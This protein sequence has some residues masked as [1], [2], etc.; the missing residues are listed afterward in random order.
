MKISVLLCILSYFLAI[1][2]AQQQLTKLTADCGLDLKAFP[3]SPVGE[4]VHPESWQVR[5]WN[6]VNTTRCCRHGLNFLS[7]A[8]ANSSSPDQPILLD[9]QR[10]A[11]CTALLSLRVDSSLTSCGFDQ[12]HQPNSACAALTP[13][14]LTD[15]VA[16]AFDVIATCSEINPVNFLTAC[17][18]CTDSISDAIQA[19]VK[20]FKVDDND[21]EKAV[22]SVATVTAVASSR[23]ANDTW[24]DDYYRCL[25]AMDSQGRFLF[26]T[27]GQFLSFRLLL[28]N[29][30]SFSS[31][32]L[33][34]DTSASRKRD[35]VIYILAILIAVMAF[36]L[37]I[38]LYRIIKTRKRREHKK[39]SDAAEKETSAWSGLYRFSKAE[40]EKAINY[41]SDGFLGAGSAGRVHQGVLPSG[42]L[43]AIKHIYTAATNLL[44]TREVEGLSKVRHHNLVSLLGYCDENGD[45]FLVYEFCSNGNLAQKLRGKS[46]LPWEKRVEILRDCSVALRFLHTHPDGCIVHRDIKLTNILLT[47]KMEPKLSDFGLAKMVGMKETQCFTDIKGTIG[48]MDPEYM[49]NGNLT[50]ASDIYSFGIVILQVLSGRKVIE[51]N[52]QARDSLTRAARDASSGKRPLTDFVDPCLQGQVNLDDFKSILRVAVL[53]ASGSSKGRPRIKDLVEELEKTCSNTQ[54]KMLEVSR[55]YQSPEVIEV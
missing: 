50:C 44:F 28:S 27:C 30:T 17:S 12:L 33:L 9:S 8:V 31:C 2:G 51:L 15:I 47:E 29:S 41:S 14:S 35:L 40:I 34:D 19:V 22:C 37:L 52:T 23:I 32:F 4:C 45:R 20:H 3:Y 48:Y 24:T 5:V 36:S 10:W 7:R 6:N 21:S 53:C 25:A 54:N 46:C 26:R 49:S 11:E 16:P 18:N 42:Q 38:A 39:G 13:S 55:Q 1:V 43:V